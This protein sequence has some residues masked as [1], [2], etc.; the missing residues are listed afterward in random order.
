MFGMMVI[1]NAGATL[2]RQAASGSQKLVFT[3]AKSGSQWDDSRADL[4]N[5][6]IDLTLGDGKVV[7]LTCTNVEENPA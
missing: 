7:R 2:V 3:R 5:K 1:T 4:A 6:T